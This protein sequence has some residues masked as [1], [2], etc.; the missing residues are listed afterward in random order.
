MLQ[1]GLP[2]EK[3]YLGHA[4]TLKLFIVYLQFKLTGFPVFLFAQV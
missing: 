2:G 1:L 4:Y 3:L